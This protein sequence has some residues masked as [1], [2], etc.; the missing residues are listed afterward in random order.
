M[1]RKKTNTNQ[2]RQCR[3]NQKKEGKKEFNWEDYVSWT[4]RV[5][6]RGGDP[7]KPMLYKI[8]KED[9]DRVERNLYDA[10]NRRLGE[11]T[12]PF[13]CFDTADRSVAINLDHLVFRCH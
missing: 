6:V 5:V 8:S 4:A 13:I 9:K 1:S 10:Y 12:V 3:P 11:D 7:E 2:G